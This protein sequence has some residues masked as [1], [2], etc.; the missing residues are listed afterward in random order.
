MN[1]TKTYVVRAECV[2]PNHECHFM[3]ETA[4]C[5]FCAKGDCAGAMQREEDNLRAVED[6]DPFGCGPNCFLCS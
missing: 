6:Y 4:I 2:C 3:V 5:T 1:E